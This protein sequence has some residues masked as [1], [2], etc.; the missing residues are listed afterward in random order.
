MK[1]TPFLGFQGQTHEA[2]LFYAQA[3]G[4]KVTSE[5]RYRDMPDMDGGPMDPGMLDHVGHS[6][7]EAGGAVLMAADTAPIRPMPG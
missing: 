2:F 6:Q 7:L 3:L 4:G 1:L 5:T